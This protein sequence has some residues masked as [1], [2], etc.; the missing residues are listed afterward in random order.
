MP[1]ARAENYEYKLPEGY[2]MDT[3]LRQKLDALVDEAGMDETLAQRFVDLHV[4]LVEDYAERLAEASGGTT[5]YAPDI[6]T[7]E[8]KQ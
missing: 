6:T 4:E 3:G 5:E 7:T 2:T 1:K 8:T